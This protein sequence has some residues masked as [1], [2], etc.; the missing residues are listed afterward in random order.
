MQQADNILL[1]IN[2]VNIGMGCSILPTYITPIGQENVVLKPMK[3]E[4]PL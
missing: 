4:L 3:P 2:L 1:N